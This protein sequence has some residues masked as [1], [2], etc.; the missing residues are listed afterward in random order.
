MVVID[1]AVSTY[2]GPVLSPAPTGDQAVQLWDAFVV[3]GGIQGIYELKRTRDVA[4]LLPPRP[5][6]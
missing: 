1:G 6:L 3:L 2:F 5:Q 4:P